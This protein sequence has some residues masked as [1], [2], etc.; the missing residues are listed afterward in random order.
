[1]AMWMTLTQERKANGQV[2]SRGDLVH[3]P[4]CVG[5]AMARQGK[6]TRV[7]ESAAKK[8]LAER[9]AAAEKRRSKAAKAATKSEK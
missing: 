1:M 4:N 8:M 3:V 6:G 7:K 2:Y 5:R 9:R